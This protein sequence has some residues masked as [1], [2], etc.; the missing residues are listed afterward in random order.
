MRSSQ[1]VEIYLE[2]GR[3]RTFAGALGWPG[4]CRSGHDEAE[5]LQTLCDYGPRYA[6]VLELA[7][8]EF[9]A[10]A[11]ASA[12]NVVERL[13]GDAATDFGAPGKWPSTDMAPVDETELLRFQALLKA[14]WQAFDAVTAAA[15]GKEL[16][17]GPRG[18][19]RNLEG[20]ILH[21][22]S[23]DTGYLS[24]LGKK[25]NDGAEAG[26]SQA[27]SNSRQIILEAL[28]SAAHGEVPAQG[29]RGGTYWTARYFVRRV[30]WHVLD[31]AWELEDR[32][33]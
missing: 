27:L 14:C 28:A 20:I 10:P 5:A 26:M 7:Q 6:G 13:D 31:H 21:V 2:I 33:P 1:K 29:P 12:F 11:V 25:F 16:Q 3:R 23:A 30:A 24:R 17:K 4:W 15:V 8:L 9:K 32:T 19:G 22:L 18:G